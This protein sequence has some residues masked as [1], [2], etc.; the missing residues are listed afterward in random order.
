MYF[1]LPEQNP[2][3]T[4]GKIIVNSAKPA[5]SRESRALNIAGL[6]LLRHTISAG[7]HFSAG[8]ISRHIPARNS[9][10]YCALKSDGIGPSRNRMFVRSCTQK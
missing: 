5:L 9:A 2:N 4:I 3:M 6:A 8:E 7:C 10:P 1:C